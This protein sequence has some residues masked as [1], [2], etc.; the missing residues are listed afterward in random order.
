MNNQKEFSAW[1]ILFIIFVGLA[2]F[3]I[4]GHMDDINNLEYRK[5]QG[6]K[7]GLDTLSIN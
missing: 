5:A 7:R 3:A 1:R 4:L 2:Y 6:D